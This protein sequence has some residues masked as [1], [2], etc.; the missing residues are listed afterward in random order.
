MLESRSTRP[1]PSLEASSTRA[2]ATAT[3]RRNI[4]DHDVAGGHTVSRH[5]DKTRASLQDR[6]DSKQKLSP[7]GT[8][9][10]ARPP[11]R[12]EHARFAH[13]APLLGI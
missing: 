9:I 5:V 7:V 13:S 12:S 11:V 4:M 10:A 8:G 2:G 3:D 1:H 6:L